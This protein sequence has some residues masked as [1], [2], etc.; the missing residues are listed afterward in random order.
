[1]KTTL[2]HEKLAYFKNKLLAMKENAEN[3]LYRKESKS[4]ND[5]IQELADYSNHPGDIGT[6]Q[7]EQQ[8]EAG[9]ELMRKEQLEEIEDALSRIEKGTYGI[10]EKS[11]KSIPE[12]RLEVMPTAR[13]R[14]EEEN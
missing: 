1:M 5:S 13:L 11:G 12:E 3:D 4:P 6:E 7:F 8:R 14:V 10:C 2:S 9:F